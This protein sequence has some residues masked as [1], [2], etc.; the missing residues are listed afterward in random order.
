MIVGSRIALE[1]LHAGLHNLG[2]LGIFRFLQSNTI[3]GRFLSSK[4]YEKQ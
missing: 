4:L 1:K 3:K 2:H